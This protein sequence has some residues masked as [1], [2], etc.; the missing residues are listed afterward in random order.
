MYA[1]GLKNGSYQP[2][3]GMYPVSPKK[4]HAADY[5]DYNIVEHCPVSRRTTKDSGL[6][7]AFM[8]HIA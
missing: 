6:K 5:A 8:S 4:T 2:S 7:R 3:T 1:H